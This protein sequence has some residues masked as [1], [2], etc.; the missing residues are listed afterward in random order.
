MKNFLLDTNIVLLGIRADN[1]WANQRNTWGLDTSVN[2]IS[3]IT[4]GELWSLSL[5]NDWGNKRISEMEKLLPHFVVVDIN[6]ETIIR[7]YAEIDAYSQGKLKDK[8]L[9]TSSRNMGKNDLWIAATASAL[10]LTL[11]TT[12]LDFEHLHEVFVDIQRV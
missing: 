9:G 2:F 11:L 7:R 10:N 12:D 3:V 5:Q 4:L 8:P 1:D 6:V